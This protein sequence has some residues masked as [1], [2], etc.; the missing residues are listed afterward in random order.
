MGLTTLIG[1]NGALGVS[2]QA[3]KSIDPREKKGRLH[4]HCGLQ[5]TN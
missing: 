1:G 3:W 4:L 5:T 2:L